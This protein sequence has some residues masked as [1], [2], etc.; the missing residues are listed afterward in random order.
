MCFSSNDTT[1]QDH[2][3][4]RRVDI[5]GPRDVNIHIPRNRVDAHGM[6]V[7]KT[8]RDLSREDLEAGLRL[9]AHYIHSKGANLTVVVVGG[10]VSILYLR[11]R[12]TTHDVD[13]FGTK[14]NM[15]YRVLL[16][17]AVKSSTAASTSAPTGSTRRRRCGCRPPCSESSPRRPFTSA[18]WSSRTVA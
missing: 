12:G 15:Q 10:A 17:E 14:L 11:S 6:P 5:S 16:D 3:P 13:V 7:P 4:A 9:M 1:G 2:Q 18:S 8:T